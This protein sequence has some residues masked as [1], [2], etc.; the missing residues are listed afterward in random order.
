MWFGGIEGRG[1]ND[2]ERRPDGS[3]EGF[4]GSARPKRIFGSIWF[5]LHTSSPPLHHCLFVKGRGA[6][7]NK[8]K[9]KKYAIEQEPSDV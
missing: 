3:A 7:E 9:D 4:I 1:C 6:G 2:V 8:V 5:I